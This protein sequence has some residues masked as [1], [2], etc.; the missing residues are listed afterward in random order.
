MIGR[1]YIEKGLNTRTEEA[2]EN[3]DRYAMLLSVP[4]QPCLRLD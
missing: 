3:N 2:E 4:L 1:Y